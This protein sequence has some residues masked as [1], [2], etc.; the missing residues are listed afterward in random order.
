MPVPRVLISVVVL[1]LFG[2]L[3]IACALGV[4]PYFVKQKLD[5]VGSM[6]VITVVIIFID[7]VLTT[8][9]CRACSRSVCTAST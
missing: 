5:T 8:H 6:N 7:W 1:L 3:F 2:A 9:C 4:L